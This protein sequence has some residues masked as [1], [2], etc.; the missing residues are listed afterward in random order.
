MMFLSMI[1]VSSI[2]TFFTWLKGFRTVEVYIKNNKPIIEN[3]QYNKK[4]INK[5]DTFLILG[6]DV[7]FEIGVAYMLFYNLFIL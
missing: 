4:L 3:Q 2:W 5:I 7:I 1:Y 6:Y